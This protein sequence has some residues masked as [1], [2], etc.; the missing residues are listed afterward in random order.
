MLKNIIIIIIIS[1]FCIS[2]II[3]LLREHL[4]FAGILAFILFLF[5]GLFIN[6]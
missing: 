5:G 1:T 3:S 2:F 4:I 6:I